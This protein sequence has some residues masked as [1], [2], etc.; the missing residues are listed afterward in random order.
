MSTAP[1][2]HTLA[3]ATQTVQLPRG[4]IWI[5]EFDWSA[6]E[7]AS[8]YGIGGSLVIDVAEK[9]EGRPITLEA[10]DDAGHIARSVLL[11]VQAMAAV[12]LAKYTLTLADGRVFTVMFSPNE[13]PVTASLAVG[14]PEV[15]IS[16]TRYVATVRLV[17][18]LADPEPEPEEP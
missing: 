15:P 6:L 4:M 8:E 10:A 9:L 1:S 13:Q 11:T 16:S 2:Y 14:R 3:S 7:S 12:P 5:D 18:V 17:T